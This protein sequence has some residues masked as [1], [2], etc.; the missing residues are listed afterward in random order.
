MLTHREQGFNGERLPLGCEVLAA[1]AT[2]AAV[3]PIAACPFK[4][5]LARITSKTPRTGTPFDRA[6]NMPY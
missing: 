5:G 1:V 6:T 2:L 4:L 3:P